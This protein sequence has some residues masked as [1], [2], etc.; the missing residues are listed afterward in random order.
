MIA[1]CSV[2]YVPLPWL[3]QVMPG[4]KIL[5]TLSGWSDANA[6]ALLDALRSGDP[7]A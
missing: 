1:T 4:G 2:R 5:V 7:K 6:L 3:H